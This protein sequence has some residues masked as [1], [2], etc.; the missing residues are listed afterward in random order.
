MAFKKAGRQ[1][2]FIR[3]QSWH[4]PIFCLDKEKKT[5]ALEWVPAQLGYLIWC[6]EGS[7]PRLGAVHW[8]IWA[9]LQAR[10]AGCQQRRGKL[11]PAGP[12][13]TPQSG[14]ISLLAVRAVTAFSEAWTRR[15]DYPDLCSS[16]CTGLWR[17]SLCLNKK[18]II[19]G[20]RKERKGDGRT[21]ISAL[22][23]KLDQPWEMW[24]SWGWKDLEQNQTGESWANGQIKTMQH[25][26]WAM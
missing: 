22:F 26:E 24:A 12:F 23:I 21:K 5:L 7:F 8:A 6:S 17:I 16:G 4:F 10:L 19:Q 2:I 13:S 15:L 1:W 14:W 25:Q 9:P 20:E 3:K 11:H 18:C